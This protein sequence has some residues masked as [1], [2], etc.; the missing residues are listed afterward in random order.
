MPSDSE[1]W[2]SGQGRCSLVSAAGTLAD[3]HPALHPEVWWGSALLPSCHLPI[4]NTLSADRFLAGPVFT[5]FKSSHRKWKSQH[6]VGRAGLCFFG[7]SLGLV[8]RPPLP[9]DS[10]LCTDTVLSLLPPGTLEALCGILEWSPHWKQQLPPL[11]SHPGTCGMWFSDLESAPLDRVVLFIG[12]CIWSGFHSTFLRKPIVAVVLAVWPGKWSQELS[13]SSGRSR[14]P[15]FQLRVSRKLSQ[16]WNV[17][18][19]SLCALF[20]HA[21]MLEEGTLRPERGQARGS[22]PRTLLADAVLES[23]PLLQ[24]RPHPQPLSTHPSVTAASTFLSG[25]NSVG[26]A[27]GDK[28]S[29]ILSFSG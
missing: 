27:A 17:R 13:Q 2:V 29:H 18:G 20:S 25:L 10:G 6:P 1:C 28:D 16:W 24:S 11:T 4:E 26:G 7:K 19:G 14:L 15:R 5:R 21:L 12:D 3:L 23:L 8:P 9:Q 22:S